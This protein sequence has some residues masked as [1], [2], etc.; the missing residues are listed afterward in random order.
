M[1]I[2]PPGMRP[3]RSSGSGESTGSRSRRW[4]VLVRL[5]VATRRA[6]H[7][8]RRD[9]GADAGFSE[10]DDPFNFSAREAMRS[11]IDAQSAGTGQRVHRL[12]GIRQGFERRE[13]VAHLAEDLDSLDGIDPQIGFHIEVEPEG[14]DRDSR[15]DHVRSRANAW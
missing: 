4:I 13:F 1:M 9:A 3:R 12:G 8:K 11:T 2:R 7:G 14:L 6:A 15:C 10:S 5:A